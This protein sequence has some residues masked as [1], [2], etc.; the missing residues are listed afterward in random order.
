MNIDYRKV[1]LAFVAAV[2]IAVPTAS[3]FQNRTNQIEAER[4]DKS[5]LQLDIKKKESQL[6]KLKIQTEDQRKKDEAEKQKL[7]EEN[8]QLQ[9]DLQAK[10]ERKAEE[11]R[12]AAA[13]AAEPVVVAAQAPAPQSTYVATGG[14]CESFRGMVAQYDWDVNTMMRIMNAESSCIPTKHNHADNHR[15]CL[16]SYGLFQIGCVHGYAVAHLESPANNIAAAYSI[17]KSQGYTAWSTY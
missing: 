6:E 4:Q 7:R 15:V 2:I 1:I 8:E 12:L 5:R 9:R 16:G 10:R 17:Y 11:A 14:G 13:K 3:A